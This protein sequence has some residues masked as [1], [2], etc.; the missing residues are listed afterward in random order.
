MCICHLSLLQSNAFPAWKLF[1]NISYVFLALSTPIAVGRISPP[2]L[3]TSKDGA[4]G[5][6][7]ADDA[8]DEIMDRLVKSVTQNPNQRPSTPKERKRS[9]ANRKS[10]KYIWL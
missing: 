2:N 9:R 7:P 6:S 3:S 4:D 5:A 10:C 1:L 8:T